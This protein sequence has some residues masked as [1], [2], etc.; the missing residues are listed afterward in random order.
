MA[1]T[2]PRLKFE[3]IPPSEL[4][5][6]AYNP[7][8]MSPLNKITGDW[9]PNKLLRALQDLKGEDLAFTGFDEKEFADMATVDEASLKALD[10]RPAPGTLWLFLGIPVNSLGE[11]QEHVAAL[12]QHA[13]IV[14]KT[15]RD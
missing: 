3:Y 4:N 13:E 15:S 1:K 5:P 10:L 9:D 11:V 12:E 7:R 14:V 6:A 8:R 2:K